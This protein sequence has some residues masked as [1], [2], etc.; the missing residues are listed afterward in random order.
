M[1]IVYDKAGVVIRC[2]DALAELKL[3]PDQDCHCCVTSPPYWNLRDYGTGEWQG[4]SDPDC[5]HIKNGEKQSQWA[6]EGHGLAGTPQDSAAVVAKYGYRDE[7][8]KCG[9]VRIDQQLGLEKTPEE[10]VAKIVEVFREV[11]RVL[12]DD[13][14]LWL[15]L[16]DGYAGSWGNYG[17]Q[18]RGHG[19]QRTIT[20]GSS[21][22]NHAYDGLES[23]RPATASVD[24]LKPKDLIGMPWR[25][26]F[27]LQADGWWLRNEIIWHK[28]NCMPESVTDRCTRDHEHV[29]MLAK[30]HRY[31]FDQESVKVPLADAN[32]QRTTD[33]YDTSGRG[34]RDGGN[35]GLDGLAARMR[36]GE[37][38]GR[39]LR[40]VWSI[41]T[42][43]YS[44][45]HFATFPPKLCEPCILAGCPEGGVVLDPFGGSG[46]VAAVA[47]AL[48]RKSIMIELNPDYIPLIRRRIKQHVLNF[49]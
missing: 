49:S 5:D 21:A 28:A 36:S 3:M 30:S 15:N 2:G 23:F 18:N 20:N 24:G 47:K 34:P 4:G 6:R 43:S 45:A 38:T 40:T 48:G 9:A 33:T 26:A 46:T 12:R 19:K 7:C 32:A 11:R 27:A 39:N 42:A 25:V 1:P 31:Y 29:F 44:A 8:G 13:G 22:L 17:G 35:R 10:Y 37:H 16:G 14:T 41:P